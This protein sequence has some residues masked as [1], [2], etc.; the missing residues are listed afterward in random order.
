[1]APSSSKTP[2]YAAAL[3]EDYYKPSKIQSRL[4]SFSSHLLTLH[5]QKLRCS[6]RNRFRPVT[7]KCCIL[8]M[9]LAIYGWQEL[10]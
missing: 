3:S 1:M 7:N 2:P 8:L 5:S 9:D 10:L 6:A 4:A